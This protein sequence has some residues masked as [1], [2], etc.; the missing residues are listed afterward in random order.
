MKNLAD[1][2]AEWRGKLAAL[3]IQDLSRFLKCSI[4]YTNFHEFLSSLKG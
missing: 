2:Q 1:L 4:P 3:L